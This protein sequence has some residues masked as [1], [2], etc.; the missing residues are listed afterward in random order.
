MSQAM[1]DG[2]EEVSV[3][4]KT[5]KAAP[6]WNLYN[7]A[8]MVLTD[9]REVDISCPNMGSSNTWYN[10]HL[11]GY[12]GYPMHRYLTDD[13]EMVMDRM[14]NGI[15][16]K[17]EL[18]FAHWIY[19]AIKDK[20][21]LNKQIAYQMPEDF[22]VSFGL[23]DLP[24][25]D[26]NNTVMVR[27]ILKMQP[28][29]R[30]SEYEL[31]NH[32]E[33]SNANREEVIPVYF[34][35]PLFLWLLRRLVEKRG[36]SEKLLGEAPIE[37]QGVTMSEVYQLYMEQ[38]DEYWNKIESDDASTVWLTSDTTEGFIPGGKKYTLTTERI[39]INHL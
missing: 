17:D 20:G 18:I 9:K 1:F 23:K 16:S 7:P 21:D 13:R 22:L 24:L 39:N 29:Q 28:V 2:A 36:M 8:A 31:R 10:T 14:N 35:K 25:V 12:P 33:L 27:A 3:N 38:Q 15:F 30:L 37:L 11:F 5:I 26:E 19:T 6:T 32:P 4:G 34:M